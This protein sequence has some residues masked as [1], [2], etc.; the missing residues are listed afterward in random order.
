MQTRLAPAL[1]SAGESTGW[2]MA[3]ALRGSVH[4]SSAADGKVL[5]EP[6]EGTAE[7]DHAGCPDPVATRIDGTCSSLGHLNRGR[8][9]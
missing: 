2:W 9:R 4:A 8:R 1:R 3:N 5:H 7:I 6:R